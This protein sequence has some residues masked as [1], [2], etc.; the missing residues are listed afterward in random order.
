VV[1]ARSAG[2]SD[3]GAGF[4][5]F[6]TSHATVIPIWSGIMFSRT[7]AVSNNVCVL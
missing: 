6:S 5:E 7:L 4:T 1:V 2:R 3:I